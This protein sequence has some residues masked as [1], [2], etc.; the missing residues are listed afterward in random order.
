VKQSSALGHDRRRRGDNGWRSLAFAFADSG[1]TGNGQHDNQGDSGDDESF[2]E[3]Y[4][5][6]QG[7]SE[8]V[9]LG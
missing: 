5:Y 4:S 8:C 2:H 6:K 1:T 9:I 7:S 3:H